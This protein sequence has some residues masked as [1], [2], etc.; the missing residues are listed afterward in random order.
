ML[1]YQVFLSFTVYSELTF[2]CCVRLKKNKSQGKAVEVI[3]NSKEENS[4]DFC[5][6]LFRE[7]GLCPSS[8]VRIYILCDAPPL[9]LCSVHKFAVRTVLFLQYDFFARNIC[10]CRLSTVI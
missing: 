10:V 6:D 4:E 7:F 5:L 1:F 9:C 8:A 3:V 2:R